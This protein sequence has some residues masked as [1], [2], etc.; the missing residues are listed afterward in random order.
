MYFYEHSCTWHSIIRI[1]VIPYPEE[2]LGHRMHIIKFVG[3]IIRKSPST[4]LQSYCILTS[5]QWC[6]DTVAAS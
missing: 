2:L 1:S 4:V 6:M 5:Y 3:G